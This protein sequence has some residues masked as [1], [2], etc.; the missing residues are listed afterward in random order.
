MLLKQISTIAFTLVAVLLS[1]CSGINVKTDVV[2]DSFSAYSTYA[3]HDDA[4]PEDSQ[5]AKLVHKPILA[6]V[7]AELADK[8][9]TKLES[10]T[11]DFYVN[12]QVT[13]E[14][15]FDVKEVNIYSGY[16]PGFVLSRSNDDISNEV[17]VSGKEFHI[18]EFRKGTLVI[19]FIDAKTD[20][21]L[22]RGFADKKVEGRLNNSERE[23][24]LQK[25]ISKLFSAIPAK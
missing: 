8:N 20:E 24:L 11:P 2:G 23:A 7:N 13:A 16:G 15:I 18:E 6:L 5:F 1:A 21:L 14:D 12:Y 19:D 3:W 4:K 9:Y 25:V 17:Y 10:G 22:W